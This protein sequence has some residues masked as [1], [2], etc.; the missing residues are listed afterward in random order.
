M[1]TCLTADALNSQLDGFKSSFKSF[2][3]YYRNIGQLDI[4]SLQDVA[5]QI[6]RDYLRRLSTILQIITSI[7]AKP[8]ISG[9]RE[10]IV[11]RV[12]QAKQLSNEEFTR[13]LR[14]GSM[15]KRYDMKL[16][17]E[18]V[19]YYQNIDELAIYENRFICLVID[20]I[21]KELT[22]YLS[23]YIKMLPSLKNN[24]LKSLD[25]K[26][27]ELMLSSVELMLRRVNYIK[28]TRFYKEVSATKPISKNIQ[29]TNILLK[30]MLYSRVYRFYREFYSTDEKPLSHKLV[31]KY[32]TALILKDLAARG[33]SL[34]E[35]KAADSAKS[36]F[37]PSDAACIENADISAPFATLCDERFSVSLSNFNDCDGL[38]ISVTD[39]ISEK[40]ARHLLQMSA[41][42]DFSDVTVKIEGFD[43]V[44]AA[45]E[46]AVVTAENVVGSYDAIYTE[47]DIVKNYLDGLL[48]VMT[49]S[50]DVYTRYCP[51]CLAKRPI[52]S[53]DV[54]VCPSC[55]SHY[56]FTK[57]ADGE[58]AVWLTRLRRTKC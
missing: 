28:N 49:V 33:F 36:D 8:H 13:V 10:E 1:E 20:T 3:A 35:D 38:V 21:F 43:T 2:S 15:W 4:N 45:S 17:P 44:D 37:E 9:K 47:A 30:D 23:F 41:E 6:D 50:G 48:A 56:V 24:I 18:H 22:S 58:K 32:Y 26:R 31:C 11:A 29:R 42:V 57:N 7:I 16:V 5:C 53:D 55:T 14:D 46:W 51:V 54:C 34:S 39:K 40:T 19:Y 52:V 27:P 25:T 12:E